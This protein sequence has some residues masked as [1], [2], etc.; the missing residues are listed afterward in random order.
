MLPS[1]LDPEIAA[2]L[3]QIPSPPKGSMTIEERRAG[4]AM[5]VAGMQKG[6]EPLLPN[7]DH[8]A[9]FSLQFRS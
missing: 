4:F 9:P 2:I 1:S 5:A 7:G 3:A 6:M 8:L